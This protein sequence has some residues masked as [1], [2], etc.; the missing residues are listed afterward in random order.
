MFELLRVGYKEGII[1]CEKFIIWFIECRHP[2]METLVSVSAC[3][4]YHSEEYI[5]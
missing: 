2:R 5:G 1:C 3:G 4:R